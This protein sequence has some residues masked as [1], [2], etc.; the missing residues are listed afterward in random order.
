MSVLVPA[1]YEPPYP[2]STF[3]SVNFTSDTG[4]SYKKLSSGEY[5]K[6]LNAMMRRF[7]LGDFCPLPSNPWS[8]DW[9]D[10]YETDEAKPMPVVNPEPTPAEKAAHEI[11][12]TTI[13]FP[14]QGEITDSQTTESVFDPRK[15]TEK[16]WEIVKKFPRNRQGKRAAM[17]RINQIREESNVQVITSTRFSH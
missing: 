6:D 17:R 10:N 2:T 12:F 4:F 14:K 16:E 11:D 15:L 8:Y 1:D 3:L 13:K 7:V 5:D 9:R